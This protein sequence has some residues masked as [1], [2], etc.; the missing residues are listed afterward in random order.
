MGDTHLL[1]RIRAGERDANGVADALAQQDPHAYG[2]SDA[3]G[4][5]RA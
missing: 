2:A 5:D 4:L 3:A 1:A